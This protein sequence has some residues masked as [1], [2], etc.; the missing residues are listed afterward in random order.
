M[1]LK[2]L[3]APGAK[4][5]V[6]KPARKAPSVP[7]PNQCYGYEP[8]PN[9]KLIAQDA[10]PD[11]Y[12][13]LQEDTVGPAFYDPKL[14]DKK[15]VR[16]LLEPVDWPAADALP[17]AL[18]TLDFARGSKRD[19]GFGGKRAAATPGPGH[20]DP[21]ASLNTAPEDL[22]S[23]SLLSQVRRGALAKSRS[24]RSTRTA[25]AG[26]Q[27]TR[28]LESAV[29][30]SKTPMVHNRKVKKSPEHKDGFVRKLVAYN[31]NLE[32]PLESVDKAM[33]NLL[34]MKKGRTNT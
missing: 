34:G 3:T 23:S 4:A 24:K 8:G 28:Q 29:F 5:P 11:V 17:Y 2:P 14:P 33:Q 12:S 9:G 13:G 10:P 6:V 19:T 20:Y 31:M 16:L 27:R 22:A 26:M 18:Q 30:R 1:S 21:G 32:G 25:P 15:G 7:R